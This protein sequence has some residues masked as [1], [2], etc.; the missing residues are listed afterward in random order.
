MSL[1]HWPAVALVAVALVGCGDSRDV[2]APAM[3]ALENAE[4]YVLLSLEPVPPAKPGLEQFHGYGVLGQTTVA[5]AAMRKRLNDALRRGARESDG[6][7]AACFNPRHGIRVTRAGKTTDLV[8][9][10]ECLSVNAYEGDQ[11]T[12]G[13]LVS[14]SPQAA[15]DDVLAQAGIATGAA[16]VK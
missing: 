11:Q 10:F 16:G 14:E 1:V 15:F 9:C 2:P 3:R 12:A 5:D 4:Q 7:V 13:F 8:I 6:R